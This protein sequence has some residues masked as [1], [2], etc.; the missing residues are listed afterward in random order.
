MG[1]NARREAGQQLQAGE[2]LL[3]IV[4]ELAISLEATANTISEDKDIWK[5]ELNDQL[6][7]FVSTLSICRVAVEHP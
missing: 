4:K 2:A 1:V 6:N 5:G 7:S 3:K